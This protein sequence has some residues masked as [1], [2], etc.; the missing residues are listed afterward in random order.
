MS[1]QSLFLLNFVLHLTTV[2]ELTLTYLFENYPQRNP[3]ELVQ[4]VSKSDAL[5]TSVP[6]R[7]FVLEVAK[8]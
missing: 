4:P 6:Q 5:F 1:G 8:V 2:A 3:K 7:P